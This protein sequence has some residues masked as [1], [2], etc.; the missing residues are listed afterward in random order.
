MPI[1]NPFQVV[2]DESISRLARVN[3]VDVNDTDVKRVVY[4]RGLFGERNK[5]KVIL[6]DT[7]SSCNVIRKAMCKR[8]GLMLQPFNHVL[9]DLMECGV[10]L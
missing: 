3:R 8:L 1:S 4:V 2:D 6:I 5:S 9:C 10:L 7:R